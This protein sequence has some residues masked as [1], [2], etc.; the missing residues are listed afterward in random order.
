M[1]SFVNFSDGG[2]KADDGNCVLKMYIDEVDSKLFT[3]KLFFEKYV[4]KNK[5]VLMKGALQDWFPLHAW[6]D[7]YLMEKVGE[8]S[9]KVRVSPHRCLE[10]V[11][12]GH[13]DRVHNYDVEV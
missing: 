7:T 6:D 1:P 10:G 2:I 8:V 5:P 9:I 4:R 3:P 13:P 11:L 12:F